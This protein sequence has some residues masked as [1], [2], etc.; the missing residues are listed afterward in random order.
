MFATSGVPPL[1]TVVPAILGGTAG[2]INPAVRA[3]ALTSLR[4]HLY[5]RF[6]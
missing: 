5:D 6:E 2:S 1:E 3:A 4:S